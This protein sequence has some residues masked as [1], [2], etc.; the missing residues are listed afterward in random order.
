METI[1]MTT[2]TRT[3]IEEYMKD[4]LGYC[5]IHRKLSYASMKGYSADLKQFAE[6]LRKHEPAI[7]ECNQ[8]TRY[9]LE[10]YLKSITD[11]FK[12]RT[13]KRKFAC[14]RSFTT[15]MEYIEVMAENPFSK[16]HLHMQEGKS[17]P[18]MLTEKEIER[19]LK[20]VH[21]ANKQSFYEKLLATR[22]IAILEIFFATGIRVSE[23]AFLKLP[24]FS[25]DEN[26]LLIHGKGNRERIVYLV[27]EEVQKAFKKYLNLRETM[28]LE[29]A[30][31]FVSRFGKPLGVQGIRNLV[32]K[33]AQ[34]AGLEK[35]VTPHF[36]RHTFASLLLES[37]VDTKYIQEF[38]GH[39][40][41]VTT[42][43][44][45]HTTEKKKRE[46]LQ[47]KH[48]RKDMDI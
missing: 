8:L 35:K 10:D 32:L 9:V 36:F 24:D 40:S 38:L 48:P 44:Y 3:T 13:I 27:E 2:E 5:L 29:V 22:D 34:L 1:K 41:L 45:L 42:Q 16:F 11:K 47:T 6:F 30:N 46:I 39:S 7:T 26:T 43:I 28:N 18:R 20:A 33:Y 21:A 31:I 4:F 19:I 17:L 23:M 15:Y 12:V 25:K 37:D 14:L